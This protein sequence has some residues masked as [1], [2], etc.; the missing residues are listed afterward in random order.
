MLEDRSSLVPTDLW[1]DGSDDSIICLAVAS[2]CR[3]R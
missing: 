3:G 1:Q 2:A